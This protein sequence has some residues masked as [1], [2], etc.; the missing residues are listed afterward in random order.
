MMKINL[1]DSRFKSVQFMS[2]EEKAKVYRGWMKFI[3]NGLK[4]DHFTNAIYEHLHHC[5]FIAH[6]NRNGFYQTYF[7]QP[8][9]TRRFLRQ[10]NR[11]EGNISAEIG[12]TYWFTGSDYHDINE[13]MC[14]VVE[15]HYD[16][17]IRKTMNEEKERDLTVAKQLLAKHGMEVKV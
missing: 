6:Y 14:E 5:S 15:T 9:M 13:A 11:N 3:S 10:F 4:W 8:E 1:F 12:M 7:T 16:R 2:K 17:L